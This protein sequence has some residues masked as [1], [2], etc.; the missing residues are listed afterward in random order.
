[1]IQKRIGKNGKEFKFYKFRTMVPNADKILEIKTI[2]SSHVLFADFSSVKSLFENAPEKI[3]CRA[4]DTNKRTNDI[5]NIST[6]RLITMKAIFAS[7]V[8]NE[9]IY[10]HLLIFFI[11]FP[12]FCFDIQIIP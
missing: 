5:A 4:T 8:Y 3:P 1:M 12:P 2:Q 9:K 6:K 10:N 11:T 7:H